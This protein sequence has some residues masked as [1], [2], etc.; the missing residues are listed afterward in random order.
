MTL[1]N[2][3][4]GR[5]G[6]FLFLTVLSLAFIT[7]TFQAMAQNNAALFNGHPVRYNPNRIRVTDNNPVNPL[8]DTT[9][10]QIT[11]DYITVEAWVY[12]LAIEGRRLSI[13]R[14]PAMWPNADPYFTYTLDIAGGIPI[15]GISDGS[16]E[17]G[18]EVSHTGP[19][20]PF[21]W[22]HLAGTYDG[23]D[24]R[25][26]VNGTLANS[27]PASLSIGE[28]DVGLYIGRF[29]AGAFPGLIDEVRLWNTER[30]ATEIQAAR[31]TEL[32]GSEENLVGYWKLNGTSLVNGTLVT[33]DETDNHN[34]LVVQRDVE[35]VY[36]NPLDSFDPPSITTP[37]LSLDVG[38]IEQ[39]SETK[40][41]DLD[42]QNTGTGPLVGLIRASSTPD[43][44]GYGVFFVPPASTETESFLFRTVNDGLMSGS[45]DMN[46][47]TPLSPD[48]Y[49]TY[50]I[51][52][53]VQ[54]V[55][56]AR[57]DANRINM[58]TYRNGISARDPY[59]NSLGLEW[60]AGSGRFAMYSTG[61]WIGATVGGEVRVAVN[62]YS[63][64]EYSPGPVIGGVPADPNN[65]IYR[66]Y[67]SSDPTDWSQWPVELGAP[68]TSS[69]D[70]LV[71]G[72][73]TLFSV[74]NDLDPGR[75]TVFGTAP[76]GAEVQQTIYGHIDGPP[77][78]LGDTVFFIYKVINKG[79]DIWEN[80]YLT[81]W[82]DP[83]LGYYADDLVG[84]D[85]IRSLGYIYNSDNNDEDWDTSLGY[86]TPPP[87][88]GF[89]VL[90]SGSP[91]SSLY[92]FS[93]HTG[94]G[95]T[96][97]NADPRNAQEVYYYMQ[98]LNAEGN[99]FIDPWTSAPTV[100]PFNG[101]PTEVPIDSWVDQGP[102]DR[103]IMLSSGPFTLKPGESREV[104]AALILAMGTSNITSITE[105]RNASDAVQ[106]LFDPL[107]V[108]STGDAGDLTPGDGICDNGLG[109]CTFRAAIQEAN[110]RPGLDYIHFNITGTGVHTIQPGAAYPG[111]YDPVIIDGT[112]Q[113]GYDGTPLIEF[114]GSAITT[115]NKRGIDISAGNSTVKGLALNGFGNPAIF[116]R[117]NGGNIIQG[118]F[119]GTDAAGG[120]AVPNTGLAAIGIYCPSNIIGGLEPGEG[121][122]I[123]GNN[124]D[125]IYISDDGNGNQVLGNYIGVD[126][127]GTND[128]GNDLDG[129][130]II[131]V[132]DNLIGPDN[133]IS[134]NGSAGVVIAGAV[135][136]NNTIQGNKIGTDIS[137]MNPIGNREGINVQAGNNIIS[138]NQI[139]GNSEKGVSL[140]SFNSYGNRVIGN[141]IGLNASGDGPLANWEGIQITGYHN[142]V[143]GSTSSD[144][145]IISGN[146]INGV[147]IVRISTD[148]I[149]NKVYGNYI[150][151]DVTGT[152]SIPNQYGVHLQA[153]QST[154]IGGHKTG[155]GNLISGNT[156]QGIWIR[157]T[158]LNPS[159]GNTVQGNYI[160]TDRTGEKSLPNTASGIV[161][162]NNASDN[163][164]GGLEPGCGNLIAFHPGWGIACAGGP[165]PVIRN[166][167]LSN[168]IHSNSGIGID[169]NHGLETIPYNVTPNDPGDGDT[170]TNDLQNFPVLTSV[171]FG[172][173]D[174]TVTGSLNSASSTDYTLQCF[175]SQKPHES[176]Y[177]DGENLLGTKTVSTDGSG[178]V[179]FSF[180]F[181]VTASQG[182]VISMTATDPA[183]N[184]SEFSNCT[185]GS[186]GQLMGFANM[187]FTIHEA[188]DP[189]IDDGSDITAIESAFDTWNAVSECLVN[190]SYT[191]A[192]TPSIADANDGINLITF[193]DNEF[194]FAPGVLA[195]AAKKI[196]MG[197]SGEPAEILDAD[198]VFNPYWIAHWKY[199][200]KTDSDSGYFDIQSVTTHEIGHV[201]GLVHSGVIKATMFY[202]IGSETNAR[203]LEKD[204][205]AWVRY[206]YPDETA[207]NESY[208]AI[209]GWIEDGYTPGSGIA[210]ALVYAIDKSAP[211]DSVHAYSDA[212]GNFTIPGLDPGTYHVA[213]EPLD[214][215]IQGYALRP[216]HISA[217]IYAITENTDFPPEYYSGI[218]DEGFAED[219]DFKASVSVDAGGIG[220]DIVIITNQDLSPPI[221]L[222]VSPGDGAG[223]VDVSSQILIAF[224]EPVDKTTV[225]ESTC[226]LSVEGTP[227]TLQPVPTMMDN[228]QKVLLTPVIPFTHSTTYTLNITSGVTDLRGNGLS[229]LYTSTFTTEDPDVDAP[230]VTEVIPADSSEGIFPTAN[231]V[232]IFSEPID[233][234][235]LEAGFTL[236][237]VGDPDVPVSFSLDPTGSVVTFDPVNTL[238]EGTTYSVILTGDVLDLSGNSLTPTFSS[239]FTTVAEAAPI[240]EYIGPSAGQTNV[241]VTT[242]IVVDFSEPIDT[243][244]VTSSS[245]QLIQGTTSVTGSFDFLY[246]N[247]RV[248]FRPAADLA[249][250]TTYTLDLTSDIQDVSS[251]PLL[252]A[253]YTSIFET[254]GSPSYPEITVVYPPAGTEGTV[255]VISGSGF[256]PDPSN[257]AV[258]FNG[259]DAPVTD[260]TL[261]SVT[262]SVPLSA[263]T[264]PLTVTV[265]GQLS[266]EYIFY[267]ETPSDFPEYF[268]VA[269]VPG[270]LNNQDVE[271][272][273]DG[274][275]AYVTNTGANSVS[276]IDVEN[277]A[278]IG[279]P[280]SVGGSPVRISVSPDGRWAYVTNFATHTV[281]VLNISDP[282]NVT[283]TAT[284]PVG[285]NPA[286]IAVTP[287]G[288]RVYVGNYTSRSL[289]II[290]TDENSGGYNHVIANV[291]TDSENRDV[292]FGPDGL[293]ALITG[294]G[295]TVLDT[296]PSSGTYNQVIANVES[297]E[298]T[299]DVDFSPDG[300]LAVVSTMAG[301]ILII[302]MMENTA[303]PYQVIANIDTDQ[304]AH[305]VEFGPDGLHIYA[306]NFYDNQITVYELLYGGSG[307]E[308]GSYPYTISLEFVKTIDVG[309]AP[310]GLA[311]DSKGERILVAN[312][313][314]G[315]VTL[316]DLSG[317]P[318]SEIESALATVN[319]L[320][321]DGT[322]NSGVANSLTAKLNRALDKLR[323]GKIKTAINMLEAFNNQVRDLIDTGEL[324]ADIGEDLI[325]R[326]RN[327][328]ISLISSG[329]EMREEDETLKEEQL[330]E[331]FSLEQNYPNPFN[332]STTLFYAIPAGSEDDLRV[333]LVIYNILG[334]PVRILVDE[335]KQPGRHEVLWDGR[336]NSNRTVPA[337]I[338]LIRFTAG[339]F[340]QIRKM[341]L[342]K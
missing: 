291:D 142:I 188:G 112:T 125:G 261:T 20:D 266:N 289:S 242:S 298:E 79:S 158:A 222:S 322:L 114:D 200:F 164:I 219:V 38:V 259:I 95:G 127:A 302:D 332:P 153:A 75:H 2:K 230:Y 106:A 197:P 52:F 323:D 155:E 199:N 268:D 116:L 260:A 277:S 208:G 123:S 223:E 185:G 287:D 130:T 46:N 69:G 328:I 192:E 4:S 193:S 215:D 226:Y 82:A 110:A 101:D 187:E 301:N 204:D 320:L 270:E 115:V 48:P 47:N 61:M 89:D 304:E 312:S 16:A 311:V 3:K 326:V 299:R 36:F 263:A 54:S 105:L 262:T 283:V 73:Q 207:Y 6:R 5:S 282:E 296:D 315:N 126:R 306:T 220:E 59:T 330:P 133:L 327:I 224:S 214:G 295:V 169:L 205:M 209:S 147:S 45:V 80:A 65:E 144:R 143:G 49:S 50:S 218:P 228:D 21:E 124:G 285:I 184:T 55:P 81:I 271:F 272:S 195:V 107:V 245:F 286:G 256:D 167:I 97:P 300:M 318:E 232:V 265:N 341:I 151:T 10:Y 229:G 181:P 253:G 138:G 248:V 41:I 186:A 109:E 325:G 31:N 182:Q 217:Y 163:V 342:I 70:P 150:G 111:I 244:T 293:R 145:N 157:G 211:H 1:P 189:T 309:E 74:Y 170:G 99:N 210:G 168:S 39:A 37:V 202:M 307:A 27:I 119:L 88:L 136:S 239:I 172:I 294:R 100:F 340:T 308:G 280:V 238:S 57:F 84:V 335:R 139:S 67:N 269:N 198:I 274:A 314:S 18:V 177:G 235:T 22:T 71:L 146:T 165:D 78:Y 135:A 14:R 233:P 284:I 173:D 132:S 90:R 98:G 113:T 94:I 76:L 24:L 264:G 43:C 290:D 9:A 63:G 33:L 62:Y 77:V 267:V 162:S 234:S 231:I 118:N 247:S 28:G 281:S 32:T 243:S 331:T 275:F 196:R 213:V 257:N 103:R 194:L 203:T 26:Y 258:S 250:N 104:T 183:G 317:T 131:N 191:T 102:G 321:T 159:N 87:A 338:Y 7:L 279:S 72:D 120:T 179:S 288:K 8:A 35:F 201:L 278:I 316:I 339:G 337:G 60:P 273:P 53:V 319:Q 237:T 303:S 254:A 149:E 160:G 166:A 227:V 141:L 128:L 249:D 58:Y 241:S 148:V 334:K 313:G 255:V 11:G 305:D 83:D 44:Y 276:V 134:G 86:G 156:D 29:I 25:L 51:A 171:E 17:S 206:N 40:T 121:N 174:V 34:D 246:T 19:I 108:N 66:T 176:G 336:D 175:A 64:S 13:V 42:I 333:E 225:N 190:F 297:D 216:A 96:Y 30:D 324:P 91:F 251:P 129:I 92:S 292:E 140:M 122:I 93:Y 252:F 56:V 236:G 23:I 178:N 240:V 221:V 212:N 15:F 180:T 12:P 152:K 117:E 137:G 85:S 161:L 154:R 329:S 68:A 310:M